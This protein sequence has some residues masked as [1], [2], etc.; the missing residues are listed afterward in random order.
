M[1]DKEA[2]KADIKSKEAKEIERYEYLTVEYLKEISNEVTY[3]LLTIVSLFLYI[4]VNLFEGT[5]TGEP[6]TEFIM[7]M[8]PGQMI[9]IIFLILM[10]G[11]FLLFS[12][13]NITKR[14]IEKEFNEIFEKE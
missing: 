6:E 4:L 9:R 7:G 8:A 5:I 1:A 14:K 10:I 13:S 2:E 11:G 12:L 3:L